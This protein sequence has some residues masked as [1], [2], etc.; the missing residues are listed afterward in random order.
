[1]RKGLGVSLPRGV[2]RISRNG[3]EWW[4]YQDRRGKPDHGSNLKL[5]DF[6]TPEFWAR[7][8]EIKRGHAGPAAGS[9]DALIA[10]YQT[11]PKYL[12]LSAGSKATYRFALDH[13]SRRWG[14]LRVDGLSAPAIQAFLDEKFASRP[15]M[16]N[17][18][19]A[20]LRTIIKWGIPRRYLT[21]NP[22]RE[23]E[24]M[25]EDARNAM[26]W[27]EEAWQRMVDTAP[28]VLSRLAVLG[29]ATGQRVSDLVTMRPKGRDGAGI[30]TSIKKTG[31]QGHWCPL[32]PR[33]IAAIDGW[34]AFPNATYLASDTGKPISTN[35]I[36][37]RFDKFVAD[38]PVL[39]AAGIHIHG[40]RAMAVCDQRIR[41]DS[42]Q[43]I[44]AAIG[45]SLGMVMHY[46][47]N[48][49]QRRAAGGDHEQN[50]AVKTEGR[51]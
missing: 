17:L 6:G 10:A 39:R 41:G 23:I 30:V 51:T 47:R 25:D 8:S 13:I 9:F 2:Y 36:R 7:I 11:H 34:K 31:K 33:D 4:Y 35:A 15:S 26:P 16:G 43:R 14:P 18:T 37:K 38:D 1:M 42:H 29:R 5:P 28:T 19:L 49:D 3:K 50:G 45:M 24:L 21:T 44:A 40:L 48:I 27:P 46:S 12:N 20:V 22:A 32:D